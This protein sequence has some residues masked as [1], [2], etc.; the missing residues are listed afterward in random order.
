[1]GSPPRLNVSAVHVSG[2]GGEAEATGTVTN[3]S[4]VAQQHLVVYAVARKGSRIVAAGRAVLPEASPGVGVPFQ[5]YFVGNPSGARVQTSA[6][7]TS[8]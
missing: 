8:F 1:P 5:V 2:T 6:P 3:R 7:P 4:S